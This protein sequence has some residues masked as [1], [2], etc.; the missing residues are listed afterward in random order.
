MRIKKLIKILQKHDPL[1]PVEFRPAWSG[2][3]WYKRS[4]VLYTTE[5]GI[6]KP[7]RLIIELDDVKTK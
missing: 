1:L 7:D 2:T 5:K 4:F 6:D 3:Q